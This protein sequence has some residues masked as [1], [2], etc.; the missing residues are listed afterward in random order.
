MKKILLSL[1]AAI[2]LF[3]CAKNAVTGRRQFNTIP[4]DMLQAEA[5]TEAF[6]LLQKW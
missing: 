1:S 3:S 6:Y 5:L 4:R 2:I